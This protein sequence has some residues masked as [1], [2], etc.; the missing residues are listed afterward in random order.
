MTPATADSNLRRR[1]RRGLR[2]DT[3]LTTR[4][5]EGFLLDEIGKVGFERAVVALSGGIDSA[6]TC[7]LAA[8][9]LGPANVLAVLMPYR[10][11]NP[12]SRADAERVVEQ[13]GVPSTLID[14][15][16]A[17]DGY[18]D[19]LDSNPS[20]KRRGNVMARMRMIALFDQSEEFGAL[21]AGTSNKTELLLGY[22]TVHGDLAS[23]VNPIGDLYKTQVRA[24]AAA[25]NVAEPILI[26]PPSADLWVGQSDEDELGFRYDEADEIFYLLVDEWYRPRDVI[27]AGYPEALVTDIVE[28]V[29][30][31]QFKRRPPII[32]KVSD[33]TIDRDFRFPRDWG[34]VEH[35][36]PTAWPP[37][38]GAIRPNSIRSWARS[39]SAGFSQLRAL[40]PRPAVSTACRP[41]S[42]A[43][44][45]TA[46]R[47]GRARSTRRSA[48]TTWRPWM[49]TSASDRM[50]TSAHASSRLPSWAASP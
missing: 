47:F 37:R 16:P 30:R 3:R 28:R 1:A 5:L 49:R 20:D 19:N 25:V 39:R 23:A 4:V 14:V 9:A 44:H 45:S 15:T 29:R 26:K 24:V 22:G 6:L 33:R 11:S 38:C 8:R 7:T 50:P 13:L 12:A 31:S 32:A 17:V 21:V 35:G 40:G 41:P 2:L 18:L 42:C 10:T 36:A 48:K 43:A 34:V 46:T 27:A